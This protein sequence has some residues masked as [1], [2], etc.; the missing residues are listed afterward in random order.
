[1]KYGQKCKRYVKE[2]KD[3]FKKD[4]ND[5][6]SK[7]KKNAFTSGICGSAHALDLIVI[8]YENTDWRQM[9][10]ENT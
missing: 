7:V 5:M 6:V 4:N 3:N 8:A 1:M 9:A 2:K 10:I